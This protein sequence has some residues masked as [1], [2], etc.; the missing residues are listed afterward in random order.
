MTASR[1]VKVLSRPRSVGVI[2]S[3]EDLQHALGLRKPPDLFELRLDGLVVAIDKMQAAMP[4]YARHVIITVAS[5]ERR[6][7]E[8]SLARASSRVAAV[9][10]LPDATYVDVELSCAKV[11]SSVLKQA[12][13]QKVR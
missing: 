6:R 2:F 11:L 12:R 8:Q 5:A 13:A 4:N 9:R 10:F 7:R 3:E 1:R